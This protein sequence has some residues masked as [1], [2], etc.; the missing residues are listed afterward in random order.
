MSD[1]ITDIKDMPPIV[2]QYWHM[3]KATWD[4]CGNRKKQMILIYIL[5]ALAN[6]AFMFQPWLI[7]KLINTLQTGGDDLLRQTAFWLGLYVGSM[8]V[9]WIFHGPARVIERKLSFFIKRNFNLKFY[10]ILTR[11]PFSWHHKNHSGNTINR[12]NKSAES[13][14]SFSDR[15]FLYIEIIVRMGAVFIALALI[16]WRVSVALFV[17]TIGLFFILNKFDRIIMR[18]IHTVNEGEHIFSSFK[19]D[20]ISNI[21]NVIT[22]NS[23]DLTRTHLKNRFDDF[24]PPYREKIILNEYKWFVMMILVVISHFAILLFYIWYHLQPS[25][26]LLLGTLV[27]IFQYMQ[28]LDGVIFNVAG[29]YLQLVQGYTDLRSTQPILESYD[30]SG[31]NDDHEPDL[32]I[33]GGHVEFKDLSFSYDGKNTVF[34]NLNLDIPAGQKVGIIGPSGAGKSSLV[35]IL[36]RFNPDRSLDVK[37]DGQNIYHVNGQSLRDAISIIP[38]DTSLFQD[39][40]MEN[41]RYG[42]PDASDAQVRAAAKKAYVHDFIKSMP[43]GYDTEVGERGVKLSGGQ[44]QR[45][46]IA[47]AILK[48]SPIL[49]LDEATSALD[50]E[51]EHLIQKSFEGLM[52]GKT[53]IAIAHRLSTISHLDRLIVMQDGKIVEDGTHDELLAQNGVYAK[54]WSLQSGGFLK[55]KQTRELE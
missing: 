44:R 37:I 34:I 47:R 45:V 48:D 9:F 41:I 12:I 39:S 6:V 27:T 21:Y 32:Q 23:A 29:L 14:Y 20:F 11:M 53:V 49:I 28:R 36:Q 15:Q 40:L 17:F 26:V 51:S 5:F 50:S 1:Q 31:I 7:G 4:Y 42:R 54:L 8:L 43:D 3:I 30:V 55:E 52:R 33:T 18:K 46:A 2:S 13:L 24:Y 10:D 16:D 35:N 19:F 38:Q 22:F 25:Q